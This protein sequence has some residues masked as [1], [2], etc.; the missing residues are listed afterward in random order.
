[1]QH[2]TRPPGLLDSLTAAFNAHDLDTA[3]AL[4]SEDIVFQ[5]TSPAPDGTRHQGHAAVRQVRA[6]LPGTTP[7]A[8]SI[9]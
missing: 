5:A 4:A 2:L 9:T 3:L 1:M 6:D 7:K 8:R